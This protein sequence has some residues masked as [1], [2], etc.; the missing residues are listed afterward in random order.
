LKNNYLKSIE[1]HMLQT[2]ILKPVKQK[3]KQILHKSGWNIIANAEYER[4]IMRDNLAGQLTRAIKSD[5]VQ[6]PEEREFL[7]LVCSF[8]GATQS[9]LF[10]DLF[11]LFISDY[12]KNG[13]FVEVGVGDGI[14][15]S[16]SR[17]LEV[18]FKW[19]G[20]LVEP[21]FNV[22]D[23]IKRNRSAVLV[24]YAASSAEG[25]LL[26]HRVATQELSYVGED[27]PNDN[28]NR[29]VLESRAIRSRTLDS[30]LEENCAPQSIDYVSID[31]EGH[32]LDVLGGFDIKRWSPKVITIEYNNDL[33]RAVAIRK[34]LLG[35]RQV[36]PALS[37]CDL[38]FVRA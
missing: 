31:V 5:Q 24:P 16:N 3:I 30:I 7:A 36:M 6:T 29:H 27:I 4:F 1:R 21:N 33:T 19:K 18:G 25:E 37:G 38:W 32:E 22:W 10:Q 8:K 2:K 11:S 14:A 12:K 13:F 9:Q 17:L 34:R 26:F 28:L 15:H 35:Y 20:L 23:A